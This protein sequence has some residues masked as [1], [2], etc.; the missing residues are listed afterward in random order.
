[1]IKNTIQNECDRVNKISEL[2]G[3]ERNVQVN[4]M[5]GNQYEI[6]RQN[7]NRIR[8]QILLENNASASKRMKSPEFNKGQDTAK[9]YF[10]YERGYVP[11]TTEGLISRSYESPNVRTVV[12]RSGMASIDLALKTSL[13]FVKNKEPYLVSFFKYFEIEA[14]LQLNGSLGAYKEHNHVSFSDFIKSIKET[15]ADIILLECPTS[16]P[17]SENIQYSK[18]ISVLNKLPRNK[19]RFLILDTTLDGPLKN[20]DDF[21]KRLPENVIV[22][23]I[24]SGI[25]FYNLGLELTN[26][27]IINIW[28]QNKSALDGMKNILQ[29]F[30]AV[31]G[32][33]IQPVEESMIYPIFNNLDLVTEHYDAIIGTSRQYQK[34]LYENNIINTV[35]DKPVILIEP[36]RML[37]SDLTKLVHNIHDTLNEQGILLS[38]GDSFGFHTTRLQA[39]HTDKG[40]HF[41]RIAPGSFF[42]QTDELIIK[43]IIEGMANDNITIK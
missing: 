29:R 38:T 36:T 7:I 30:R 39:I 19:V 14:L 3:I 24:V 13:F 32:Q 17:I 15:N 4:E 21:I 31:A 22:L 41:L 28:T 23:D 35:E 33:T 34:I 9:S 5:L 6:I 25:K 40:Q 18:V 11:Y 16:L 37:G 27:G 43:N 2:F 10:S 1:M 20:R 8:T 26:L 42:S 12:T